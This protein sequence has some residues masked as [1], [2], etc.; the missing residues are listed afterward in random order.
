[1]SMSIDLEVH[2]PNRLNMATGT[3]VLLVGYVALL[4]LIGWLRT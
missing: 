4:L 3:I 1:M 2:R